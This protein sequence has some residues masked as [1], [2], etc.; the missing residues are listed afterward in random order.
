MKSRRLAL[1]SL[2]IL[3][4]FTVIA[5]VHPLATP[6]VAQEATKITVKVT[7]SGLDPETIEVEQ[8]KLVEIT[9]IW[10]HKA[11]PNEEH[12]MVLEGYNVESDKI[13]AQHKEATIKIVANK[14]GTFTFK[15]DLECD[16]HDFLQ[17]GV[18][19]VKTGSGGGGA[20]LTKTKISIE[21]AAISIK[22]GKVTVN[23]SLLDDKDQPIP[24]G[25]ITFFINQSFAGRSGLV[26]IGEE[27]TGPVGQAR[28]VYEPT[29]TGTLKLTAKF[30][31][32]GIYD[33]SELAVDIPASRAFQAEFGES[34][35][36]ASGHSQELVELKDWA[37]AALISLIALIW[38]A[39]IFILYQAWRV[40]RVGDG[41]PGGDA[42]A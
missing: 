28:F 34:V 11:Y 29:L 3:L 30:E 27:R 39:F 2:A 36:P 41:G 21:P 26:E 6:A 23:A 40:S 5:G 9:F 25:D 14:P 8:G 32:M 19:K 13:D 35:L 18:L 33:A 38:A 42:S 15:C 31:G 17:N 22:D 7:D 37:P 24:K 16:L 10:D 12:I 20:A 1:A 4:A